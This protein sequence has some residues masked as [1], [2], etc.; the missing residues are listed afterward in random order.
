MR[1]FSCK[2]VDT[3]LS[4]AQKTVVIIG[5]LA[6][7]W[8]FFLREE[9]SPH[10]KLEIEPKMMPGC[11]LRVIVTIENLGGHVWTLDSAVTRLYQPS[12]ERRPSPS[13][14]SLLE[15]GT[16]IL[17][18][19]YALRANESTAIGF[20]IE[21]TERST[22]S[23]FVVQTALNIAEENQRWLRVQESSVLAD[24]C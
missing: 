19:D 10:V 11:V 4:I 23:F 16:Q 8:F 1:L 24:G 17:Q 5:L 2:R 20:T 18:M 13:D 7:G 3:W 15:V 12:L 6:S 22:H 9:T 14:L 21:P